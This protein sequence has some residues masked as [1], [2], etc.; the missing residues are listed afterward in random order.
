MDDLSY[1]PSCWSRIKSHAP[2]CL[3]CFASQPEGGWLK[4]TL[5]GKQ[6]LGGK[7]RVIEPLGAGGFGVTVRAVQNLDGR[8]LGVVALK[9]PLSTVDPAA[10]DRFYEEAAALRRVSHPNI[11]A[12]YDAFVEDSTPYLV[13][14]CVEGET[15]GHAV[16]HGA[17]RTFGSVLQVIQQVAHAVDALHSKGV[18]HCDLKPANLI[19]VPWISGGLYE[20]V[21]VI[22]FGVASL[23]KQGG[24]WQS[25]GCTLGFAPPEQMAGYP[26][27]R[28]DLFAIAVIFY[29]ML[30]GSLPY[31][32]ELCMRPDNWLRATPP[33]LPDA[34]PSEMADLIYR[35]LE[36]NEQKRY[37]G[38][39]GFIEQ[40]AAMRASVRETVD[41]GQST[42]ANQSALLKLAKET[43][44]SAG[45]S[46]NDQT[47]KQL[48]RRAHELYEQAKAMGPVPASMARI[49]DRAAQYGGM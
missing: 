19:L 12:L 43:F 27:P 35:C 40:C 20:F 15:L 3:D 34:V 18:I 31:S 28:S 32:P 21:K 39:P 44:L 4:E 2:Y 45:L 25:T 33:R 17:F 10:I 49:L 41:A 22:D 36:P 24:G 9:F 26:T 47:K 16:D 13:M 37:A 6:I 30:T 38:L 8:H 1:C 7:Y 23:W 14:Q 5:E 11:V 46:G 48:Y 29:W 42:Q